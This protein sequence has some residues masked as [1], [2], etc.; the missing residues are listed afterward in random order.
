MGYRFDGKTI[1]KELDNKR[2]SSQ[3][4][5][6]FGLM[7]DGKWRTL[8]EISEKSSAPQASVSARLR[9]FRK[10]RF[11]FIEVERRR[12]GEPNSGLHEYR[13][14]NIEKSEIFIG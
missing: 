11:G 6:V 3:V 8:E 5:R 2:L 7:S 12:K 10:K 4:S 1:V 9:D 13:L 14:K